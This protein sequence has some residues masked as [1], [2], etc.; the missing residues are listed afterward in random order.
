M[1]HSYHTEARYKEVIVVLDNHQG[2]HHLAEE[3]HAQLRRKV[4]HAG[5]SLL[6]YATAIDH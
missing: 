3:F 2:E 4:Q 5:E 6:Q 1:Q